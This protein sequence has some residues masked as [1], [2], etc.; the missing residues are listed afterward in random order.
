[1]EEKNKDI[2]YLKKALEWGF[3]VNR[4]AWK[5]ALIKAD[6]NATSWPSELL[7]SVR[8]EVIEEG[9]VLIAKWYEGVVESGLDV[10]EVSTFND[11]PEG[12]WQELYYMNEGVFSLG[13][14]PLDGLLISVPSLKEGEMPLLLAPNNDGWGVPEEKT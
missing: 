12:L 9:D 11:N 1:M 13:P 14:D 8:E 3:D 6:S 2:H 10:S 5:R 7:I 4:P